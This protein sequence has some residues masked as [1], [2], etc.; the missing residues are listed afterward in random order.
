MN[1]LLTGFEPFDN[2]D[3]NPSLEIARELDRRRIGDVQVT[4]RILPVSMQRIAV[5]LDTVLD[6]TRPDLVL[7]LGLAGHES[8]IRIERFGMNLAD[9]PIADNDGARSVD[10]ALIPEGTVGVAT[11]IPNRAIYDALLAAGIPARLSNTAGL[12]LC[13]ACIYLTHAALTRRGSPA[14]FGFL[15]LPYLPEQVAAL[16]AGPRA[17]RLPEQVASMS[18]ETMTRAV[19]IAIGSC[20]QSNVASARAAS[21]S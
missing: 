9:F 7:S 20:A 3:R 13:N 21:R 1:L 19:E 10:Q 8:M 11:T 5:A 15:H 2:S 4:S 14:R 17:G 18:L 6:E 12:Y 16:L